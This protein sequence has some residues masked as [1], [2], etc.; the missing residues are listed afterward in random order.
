[1][2]RRIISSK[3]L[4]A[5]ESFFDG[6]CRITVEFAAKRSRIQPETNDTV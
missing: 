6:K 2:V 4:A 3:S 1:M 5:P